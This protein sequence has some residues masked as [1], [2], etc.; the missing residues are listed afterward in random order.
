MPRCDAMPQLLCNPATLQPVSLGG[1]RERG[2]VQ[3]RG[4]CP[5]WPPLRTASED[6]ETVCGFPL[7]PGRGRG[8]VTLAGGRDAAINVSAQPLNKQQV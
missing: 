4:A 2:R 6:Y 7:I 1:H 3:G 5:P 8:L